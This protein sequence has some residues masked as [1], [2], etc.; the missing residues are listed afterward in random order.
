MRH[1]GVRLNRAKPT[2][3][4]AIPGTRSG[5]D[6]FD[7]RRGAAT[8]SKTAMIRTGIAGWSIGSALAAEFPG[9]GSNLSRY[10]GRLNAAEINSSFYRPHRRATYE[11]WAASVPPDFRFTVKLPKA[12]THEQRLVDCDDLLARF[13]EETGGLGDKRGPILAQLPPSFA[14]PGDVAARFFDSFDRVVGGSIVVEPRHAGWFEAEADALLVTHR[15]ARVAADPALHPGAGEPGGW[16]AIAYFRLHG[17]PR[18]YWSSYTAE[19][20]EAQALR[21]KALGSRG[22]EVWT[23]YDNTASGAALANA[24]ELDDRLSA[25]ALPR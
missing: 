1:F 10:A 14:F 7:R 3:A 2:N 8:M 6:R 9:G 5:P 12:I 22:I 25:E 23:I 18:V 21:V 17:A 24:L 19:A 20:I 16:T 4:P 11:K 15:I 13:A